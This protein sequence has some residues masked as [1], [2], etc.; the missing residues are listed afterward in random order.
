[1]K[2]KIILGLCLLA[3]F[4]MLFPF[5][6]GMVDDGGTVVYGS[7]LYSVTKVHSICLYPDADGE[8]RFVEGTVV[9]ILGFEVFDN[10]PWENLTKEP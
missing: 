3:A 9:K 4:I 5:P 7:A 8:I 10:V 2:R 1:M 6:V